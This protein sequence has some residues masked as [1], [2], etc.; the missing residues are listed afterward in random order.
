MI[1][2]TRIRIDG[3]TQARV[4]LDQ[5][6]VDDYAQAYLA[7]VQMPPIT[8]FYDGADW[9]LADGFHRYF[10]AKAAGLTKIAED[11]TPGTRRDAL[12]YSLGANERHGLRRTNADKRK[13]VATALADAE[14]QTWS[15]NAIAKLCG[16]DHKTVGAHRASILGN[17]QDSG[18]K[19][20]VER[21]GKTYQQD[22]KNIGRAP[23]VS[24]QP[25]EPQH[26][27]D[28]AAHAAPAPPAV[29]PADGLTG[30]PPAPRAPAAAPAPSGADRIA[31]L[32]AQ[33]AELHQMLEGT[34]ADNTEMAKVF[35]A[36]DRLAAATG[37]ITRLRAQNV[38]LQSR[39]DGLMNEKNEAIRAAKTAQ[40]KVAKLEKELAGRA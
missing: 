6:V 20:V 35:E 31:E 21:N 40:R 14:W 39:V 37:E 4:E 17:S 27:E 36:D 32:E 9:W 19:R 22:T 26:D 15:D 34:L 12:A 13:A 3:G 28:A 29:A 11:I 33:L 1:E 5:L 8:L 7:G 38:V 10:G 2:L 25:L 23:A 18:A 30:P 24:E 16:V